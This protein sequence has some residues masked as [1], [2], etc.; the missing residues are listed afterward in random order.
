MSASPQSLP[1]FEDVTTAAGRL[2]GV[3]V[4]TPFVE[5]PALSECVGGRVFLKLETLQRTGS[6]KFRGAYNRLVQLSPAERLRGVVAFSSGNHAQGVAA[7][8]ALLG[9]PA[10]IVMPADAPRIKTENTRAL[11]AVVVPYDRKREKREAIAD[12]IAAE[13]GAVVVPSFDDPHIV[14]GQGTVGLEIAG[15]AAA[16]GVALEAVLV[17]CSGGGLSS[18]IALALRGASPG[19]RLFTVE[20]E[21]YDGTRLSLEAGN[22]IG[23]VGTRDTIADAL[24]SPAPGIIPFAVLKACSAGGVAVDDAAL[25]AAVGF[26]AMKVKLVVEPGGA[27]ALAAVLS[28][29]FDARDKTIAIVLS[30]GNIDAEMLQRSLTANPL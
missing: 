29:A 12:R 25:M 16:L 23:A 21:G 24:T 2:A 22:R 18:G 15:Q 3:A 8:A 17:P 5:S 30:G 19:T 1:T 14:A 27:A 11:G 7:A 9:I 4:T 28:R 26:A 6:F 10:T 20:P 13:T